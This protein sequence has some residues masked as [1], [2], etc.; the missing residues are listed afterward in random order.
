MAD[1]A[2]VGG[3]IIYD[4]DTKKITICYICH[5]VEINVKRPSTPIIGENIFI[6]DEENIPSSQNGQ[7]L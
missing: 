6:E 5:I 4:E 3:K 1:L 7:N 2:A